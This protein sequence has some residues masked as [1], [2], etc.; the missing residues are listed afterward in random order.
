MEWYWILAALLGAIL[1]LMFLGFPVGIA[2]IVVNTVAAFF[3]FGPFSSG[4]FII[5]PKWWV[6]K[7]G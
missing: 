2:F 5:A 6:V 7:F 4:A 3:L 1:S